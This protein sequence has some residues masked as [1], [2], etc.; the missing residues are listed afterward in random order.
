MS[1]VTYK[2]RTIFE[3]KKRKP[4]DEA[5]P[6]GKRFTIAKTMSKKKG[7]EHVQI[8]AVMET[9]IDIWRDGHSVM[10]KKR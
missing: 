1:K 7:V 8:I 4:K 2:L 6:D 10:E 3:D 9:K 5:L